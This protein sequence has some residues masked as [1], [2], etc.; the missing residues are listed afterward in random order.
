[1]IDLIDPNNFC[2][3]HPQLMADLRQAL[4][5]GL[6]WWDATGEDSGNETCIAGIELFLS[7]NADVVYDF[8][9]TKADSDPLNWMKEHQKTAYRAIA[10]C[11]LERYIYMAGSNGP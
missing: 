11:A 10:I 7:Q 5:N 3:A 4:D 1:M 2:A 8:L 9:K 6:A